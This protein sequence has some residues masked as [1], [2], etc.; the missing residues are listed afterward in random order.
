MSAQLGLPGD[1]ENVVK[2]HADHSGICKFG[3][4]QTDQD[5]LKIVQGNIRDLYK[6]ALKL[7]ELRI[8]PSL[9]YEG[10]K[11]EEDPLKDRLSRLRGNSK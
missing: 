3:P 4:S 1:R 7:S 11:I 8:L 2:I 5:N 10:K 9:S 6:E